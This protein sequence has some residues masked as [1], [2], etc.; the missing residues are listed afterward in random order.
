MA[1]SPWTHAR[2]L[3][4]PVLLLALLAAPLSGQ[5][6][7]EFKKENR[8][9]V[10]AFLL[11]ALARE[12]GATTSMADSGSGKVTSDMDVTCKFVLTR[13]DGTKDF[14]L[15]SRFIDAARTHYGPPVGDFRLDEYGCIQST[16]LD[17]AVHDAKNAVPDFHTALSLNGFFVKYMDA[18]QKKMANPDAYF[19]GGGNR[20]QVDQRM[21]SKSRLRIF[22][23]DGSDTKVDVDRSN[24]DAYA[25]TMKTYFGMNPE[26]VLSRKRA[27]DL[28]G[29]SFD[30][31]RQ[32]TLH[33]HGDDLT[34][35]DAKYN[36]R[37][38][39]NYLEIAG[40]P[41]NWQALNARQKSDVMARLFPQG[42]QADTR[43]RMVGLL[44]ESFS[45]YEKRGSG[46]PGTVPDM[47]EFREASMAFQRE[48]IAVSAM[49]RI[50]DIL[51]PRVSLQ[52]VYDHAQALAQEQGK[53]WVGMDLNERRQFFN[54]AKSYKGELL[55]KLKFSAAGEMAMALKFLDSVPGGRAAGLKDKLLASLPPQQQKY[56][57]LQ[58]RIA[59]AY[60]RDSSNRAQNVAAE[61]RHT[62]GVLDEVKR[63]NLLSA[64]ALEHAREQRAGGMSFRKTLMFAAAGYDAYTKIQQ[65]W[66]EIKNRLDPT[67]QRMAMTL[68]RL[69]KAQAILNLIKVYQD[70]GGDSD[71]MTKAVYIEL[72]SRNV[73]GYS[74]YLMWKQWS[75]GDP[76]AQEALTQ[77]LVF[78]GLT[79]LPGGAVAQATKLVFDIARTGL[80][81]T[82]GYGLSSLGDRN[83]DAWLR[84]GDRESILT[85]VPGAT[86]EEQRKNFSR[87]MT[88][89][90]P[91]GGA[92]AQ[93]QVNIQKVRTIWNNLPPYRKAAPDEQQRYQR[94]IDA[95]FRLARQRVEEHVDGYIAGN[96]IAGTVATGSRDKMVEILFADFVNGVNR[97]IGGDSLRA[98]QEQAA[99]EAGFL[100]QVDDYMY[101]LFSEGLDG[102]LDSFAAMDP[103]PV[104]PRADR[105]TLK[106]T[107]MT[108]DG[109]EITADVQVVPPLNPTFE[110]QTAIYHLRLVN[111]RIEP[112]PDPAAT[113]I[114]STFT[115]YVDFEL[116]NSRTG[117]KM[118]AKTFEY[119]KKG[120]A[121]PAGVGHYIDYFGEGQK[122]EKSKEFDF[123]LLTPDEFFARAARVLGRTA[124]KEERDAAELANAQTVSNLNEAELRSSLVRMTGGDTKKAEA[125]L[126]EIG[127]GIRWIF[128]HGAYIDYATGNRPSYRR[129]FREGI[130]EG[131]HIGW[132]RNG[133]MQEKGRF[134]ANARVG[135]W[136]TFDESERVV[137]TEFY[138]QGKLVW[139]HARSYHPNGRLSVDGPRRTIGTG[140]SYPNT[141][142]G[143][144]AEYHENGAMQR[145]G[146]FNK[147]N[148][149]GTWEYWNA[150]GRLL[151]REVYSDP[152]DPER[153]VRTTAFNPEGGIEEE[154][155]YDR[156]GQK[157][158]TWTETRGTASVT[159]EYNHGRVV[160]R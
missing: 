61:M 118:A 138:E 130:A 92:L 98:V 73:P 128:Y 152:V 160:R 146:Q 75:S 87:F 83:V 52:D 42:D 62:K 121:A 1:H 27:P 10:I 18:L 59:M 144:F 19:T 122:V 86:V 72:M 70:S 76:A 16:L 120:T 117:R 101:G 35:G 114:P 8:S 57:D 154:G 12:H 54:Q 90:G 127:R 14:D 67:A 148:R 55:R 102:V 71:A 77:S 133:K 126:Q 119:K 111:A 32:A 31:F 109:G 123:I 30:A 5:G 41:G 37:I 63:N 80:E 43:A 53:T 34:R 49:A 36:T 106:C 65:D 46:T 131:E 21:Q 100:D 113:T 153:M 85:N 13:P 28:F 156:M 26:E 82:I 89:R 93:A 44:D 17:T 7:P 135:E 112:P 94:K 104:P 60:L 151:Q 143:P 56:V 132:H 22:D 79:L 139:S 81:I 3:F 150:T 137:R 24:A 108:D 33:E 125:G 110:E 48:A 20:K 68:D 141:D 58:M 40:Y 66:A 158:G 6:K 134:S 23:A 145:R 124:T 155:Y 95:F 47:D 99:R 103:R 2:R 9:E 142:D 29:D 88:E 69:D 140:S 15:T 64:A 116:V 84:G 96:N 157:H 50:K 4:L 74:S 149:T 25:D 38:V 115:V 129:E 107:E 136:Q 45:I 97:Q 91:G 39:N 78:Q 159:V 147:G 105:W 11:K 51:D